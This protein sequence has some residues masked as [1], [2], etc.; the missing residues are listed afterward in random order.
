[1]SKKHKNYLPGTILVEADVGVIQNVYR[2]EVDGN[3]YPLDES[4]WD[5]LNWDEHR[6]A[7]PDIVRAEYLLKGEE[8]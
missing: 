3:F 7:D 1:M 8:T 5:V 6:L 2:M 4:K